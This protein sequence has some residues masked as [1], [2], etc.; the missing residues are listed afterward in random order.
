MSDL[1]SMLG[2]IVHSKAT[3]STN[4]LA[5]G[6]G[7][8]LIARWTYALR[9][10]SSSRKAAGS[11]RGPRRAGSGIAREQLAAPARASGRARATFTHEAAVTTPASAL[12]QVTAAAVARASVVEPQSPLPSAQSTA[13]GTGDAP[14]R[15]ED[16]LGERAIAC[17]S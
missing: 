6:L 13:R 11:M 12:E 17:Y 7:L 4:A 10:P 8:L 14:V 2:S 1:L 3:E 15:G 9:V 5:V 16:G